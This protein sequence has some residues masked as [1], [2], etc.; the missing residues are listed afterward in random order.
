MLWDTSVLGNF[1]ALAFFFLLQPGAF[2]FWFIIPL[3]CVIF[4]NSQ[5]LFVVGGILKEVH[6]SNWGKMLHRMHLK[7]QW[8]SHTLYPFSLKYFVILE[9]EWGMEPLKK[10]PYFFGACIVLKVCSHSRQSV[11]QNCHWIENGFSKGDGKVLGKFTLFVAISNNFGIGGSE[12]WLSWPT[13]VTN[14]CFC[15]LCL[16]LGRISS[17][18]KSIVIDYW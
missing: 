5:F 7:E 4:I 2:W 13:C 8:L 6:S 10:F 14:T 17:F 16:Y 1:V 15:E 18:W 9:E 11:G 12:E 3:Q